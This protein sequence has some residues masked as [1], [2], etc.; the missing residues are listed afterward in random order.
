MLDQPMAF[1]RQLHGHAIEPA[2]A[3]PIPPLG[4]DSLWIT[5]NRAPPVVDKL[6]PAVRR[7]S[8]GSDHGWFSV[9][10]GG[11]PPMI[12]AGQSG[13]TWRPVSSWLSAVPSLA[14]SFSRAS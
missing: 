11:Q 9:I 12:L 14:R 4:V 8:A 6:A 5:V 10:S 1:G 2:P 13:R 7:I 3:G